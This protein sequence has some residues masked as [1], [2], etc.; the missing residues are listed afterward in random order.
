MQIA[1]RLFAGAFTKFAPDAFTSSVGKQVDF[2]LDGLDRLPA[3][4]IN[5]EVVGGGSYVDLLV[6]LSKD[7]FPNA[8]LS[9]FSGLNR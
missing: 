4:L 7:Y 1:F 8:S 6:E 2:T 5:A 9:H 3:K